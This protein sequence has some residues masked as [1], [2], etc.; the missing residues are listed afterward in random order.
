VGGSAADRAL[1]LGL[2]AKLPCVPSTLTSGGERKSMKSMDWAR[3]ASAESHT[4]HQEGVYIAQLESIPGKRD[5]YAC[6]WSIP[7]HLLCLY[8]RNIDD[9]ST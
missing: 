6:D 4:G 8:V 2:Q 5:A 7:T 3:R 9:I 1:I